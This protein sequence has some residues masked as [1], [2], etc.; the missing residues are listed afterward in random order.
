MRGYG[1]MCL[2]KDTKAMAD[3]CKKLD[4]PFELFD[5]MDHDNNQ[6]KCTVF[7]GMRL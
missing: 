5:T 4:L 1:G 2:P 6:V 3:L 7:P